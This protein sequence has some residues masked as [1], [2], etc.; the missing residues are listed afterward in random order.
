MSTTGST[1]EP[2]WKAV[3][4]EFPALASWSFL[5]TATYG[6][7]PKRSVQ[8]TAE[9]FA[10][11]DALACMD[12]LSWFDDADR[13]RASV[14]RLIQC[15]PEDVAFINNAASALSLLMSGL[16]WQPGDQVL[17][18]EHEFPNNLYWPALLSQQGVEFREVAYAELISSLTDRTRLVLISTINYSTGFRVPLEE[19]GRELR[20]RGILYYIDGTQSMGALQ[21]NVRTVQPDMLAVH[22]Y[23]WLISP[24]GARVPVCQPRVSRSTTTKCSRLAQ[25]QGLAPCGQFASWRSRVRRIS[26]EV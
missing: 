6:Q 13:I 4:A 21:F 25:P 10:H 26:R 18:L 16:D 23:K 3:R 11:R 24:N 8:A 19:L 5:N 9:H 20:R 22:A 2:D 1:P 14:A 15:R 12:F 17:S 7:L